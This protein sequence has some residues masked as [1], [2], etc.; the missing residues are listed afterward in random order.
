MPWWDPLGDND[1]EDFVDN[2]RGHAGMRPTDKGGAQV[3]FG[4]FT[5][6]LFAPPSQKKQKKKR[7][8][9]AGPL[10]LLNRDQ[11]GNDD[12]KQPL[13]QYSERFKRK[14]LLKAARVAERLPED[15]SAPGVVFGRRYIVR[16]S[17]TPYGKIK[18]KSFRSPADAESFAKQRGGVLVDS[19]SG[20]VIWPVGDEA[21]DSGGR[22]KPSDGGHLWWRWGGE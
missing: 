9:F 10:F 13:E 17:R 20:G 1:D 8:A 6:G 19:R 14:S 5:D 15:L 7:D 22:G 12:G 3:R 4:L 21:R 2:A 11:D 16:Y 18:R